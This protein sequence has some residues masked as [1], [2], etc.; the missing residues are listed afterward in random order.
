MRPVEVQLSG[1]F[2]QLPFQTHDSMI[3]MA[4]GMRVEKARKDFHRLKEQRAE[5][6]L[7]MN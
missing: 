2:Y 5:K 4:R 1:N 6:G 3:T 7:R